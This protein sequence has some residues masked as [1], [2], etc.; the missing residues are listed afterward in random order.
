ML[1]F[2]KKEKWGPVIR[3]NSSMV[4]EVFPIKLFKEPQNKLFKEF[5]KHDITLEMTG[6]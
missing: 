2:F 6:Y 1:E 4:L 3:T 5:H